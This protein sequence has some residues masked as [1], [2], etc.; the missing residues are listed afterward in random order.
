M[1]PVPASTKVWLAGGITDMGKGF[2][3]LA[4]SAEAILN[5]DPYNG[6][7][8]VFRSRR[9]DLRRG[10]LSGRP[11]PTAR[12]TSLQP[13]FPCC[14]KAEEGQTTIRGIVFSTKDWR[15]PLRTWRPLVAG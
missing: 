14:S 5:T 13:N 9:G 7:L 12:F 8:F 3:G 2:A 4:A 11:S 1:I 15:M 6:H 10:A